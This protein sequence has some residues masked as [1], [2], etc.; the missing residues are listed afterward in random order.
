ML[1]IALLYSVLAGSTQVF[2]FMG[3]T[4]LV[5]WIAVRWSEWT[6]IGRFG[7]ANILTTARAGLLGVIPI[8]PEISRVPWRGLALLSFLILDGLDGRVARLLKTE[9]RFGAELD[10]E[11]DAFAVALVAL[12]TRNDAFF[13]PWLLILAGA[14][15]VL[16]IVLAVWSR[17]SEPRRQ[18]ARWAFFLL[19][20]GLIARWCLSGNFPHVLLFVGTSMVSVSFVRSFIWAF[21]PF[22]ASGK[23]A[24]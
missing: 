24:G 4:V 10:T 8:L 7:I 13:G 1:G 5:I 23:Q 22:A 17:K 12:L 11:V 6:P 14:R 9:S 21:R 2:Q 16:V 20:C 19:M 18:S 3:A 15:Y